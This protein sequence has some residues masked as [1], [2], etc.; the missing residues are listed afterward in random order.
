MKKLSTILLFSVKMNVT[1]HFTIMN[2]V[3]RLNLR[4]KCQYHRIPK[5]DGLS[6]FHGISK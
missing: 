5:D 3:I 6:R 4:L 1:T 2:D